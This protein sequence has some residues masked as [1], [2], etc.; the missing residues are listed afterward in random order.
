MLASRCLAMDYFDCGRFPHMYKKLFQSHR[1]QCYIQNAELCW[2]L[3]KAF[4]L[5]VINM[6]NDDD[7]DDDDNHNNNVVLK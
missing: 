7:D 6:H 2:F 5:N 1:Y 3:G 4:S